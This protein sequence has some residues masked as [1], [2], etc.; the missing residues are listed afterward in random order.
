M[1][2]ATPNDGGNPAQLGDYLSILWR[3]RW[4]V[5][6]AVLATAG[7]A[8][9]F[10]SR[11]PPVYE[12]R[13]RVFIGPRAV[14]SGDIG[15]ALEELTFSREF[16]PSYAELLK[17]R[18]LAMRVVRLEA[19]PYSAADLSTRITTRII[20][21]TRI[22]EVAVADGQAQRA[23]R[24]ANTLTETFVREGV[25]EF[26]SVGGVRASVVEP[27]L[28]PKQPVSPRPTRDALLGALI[29]SG[30]GA[31]AASLLDH[32][33]DT[34]RSRKQVES[35]LAPLPVLAA[36]PRIRR[37]RKR[38]VFD[39][40]PRSPAAEAFRSL[41]TSIQLSALDVP[42]PRVLVTSPSPGEGKTLV[43]ANLAASFAMSGVRTILIGTDLRR[44]VV[45]EHLR[46]ARSPGVTE[47][48]AG[49]AD[50]VRALH[51]TPL[52]NLALLPAGKACPNPSE[53]LGSQ[54]MADMLDELSKRAEI[55]VLDSP[56]VLAVTDAA[57]L[58]AHADGVVLVLRA[59]QSQLG[60][61][62]EVK[63]A[64]DRVGVPMLGVVLNEVK[65]KDIY[66]YYRSYQQQYAKNGSKRGR[67]GREEKLFPDEL[68]PA[69]RQR[70]RS[71]KAARFPAAER[72]H[73]RNGLSRS[74]GAG[75]DHS[76][77]PDG[78]RSG[79]V[80]PSRIDLRVQ[81]MPSPP[82][83]RPDD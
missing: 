80:P 23:Q 3:R 56:P 39:R 51:Q 76:A 62:Q 29:G 4:V 19:L 35:A 59:G 12:A 10:S 6:F 15:A 47:V 44:P 1:T 31:G 52:S 71:E 30:I 43:A 64:F 69:G 36:L 42:I 66:S 8:F 79:E 37:S 61:A 70:L 9:A 81:E 50:M 55:L 46:A 34:L 17:S 65:N 77:S 7:A 28:L 13:A 16:I 45:H 5:A 58:A 57:V 49:T 75:A 27:A 32:L 33:D 14:L 20:P 22:I 48:V 82:E 54:T 67:R 53:L 60:W 18:P 25:E 2:W 68:R 74:N 41:R 73:E 78:K 40:D 63:A 83:Q 24:I 72:G 11:K 21:D 38:L 26:G